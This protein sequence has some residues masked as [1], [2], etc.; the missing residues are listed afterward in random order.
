MNVKK[1]GA[2]L[3]AGITAGLLTIFIVKGSDVLYKKLEEKPTESGCKS[4]VLTGEVLERFGKLLDT[5]SRD[6]CFVNGLRQ[7]GISMDDLSISYIT[8]ADDH[9]ITLTMPNGYTI[10]IGES[11]VSVKWMIYKEVSV[12]KDL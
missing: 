6:E 12:C 5:A 8:G 1:I 7:F 11:S 2:V 4:F 10:K 9:Y 3:T